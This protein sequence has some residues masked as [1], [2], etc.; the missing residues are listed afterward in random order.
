MAIQLDSP[1][2]TQINNAVL[3]PVYT[4][5]VNGIDVTA[6]LIDFTVN[7][8][9]QFGAASATFT[10]LNNGG[11]FG[12]SGSSHIYVAEVDQRVPSGQYKNCI[13]PFGVRD[14]VGN[15]DQWV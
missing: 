14:M 15:V 9:K 4:L 3:K 12:D 10:L 2:T 8:D 7:F 1:I 5:T 11:Q 13:S 6:Y